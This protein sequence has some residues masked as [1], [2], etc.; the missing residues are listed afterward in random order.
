MNM[1]REV[2][3][4]LAD[5]QGSSGVTLPVV[6][7]GHFLAG[8]NSE[9]A[10]I[11]ARFDAGLR[12][13]GFAVVE[14]H[15]IPQSLFDRMIET[16]GEFFDLAVEDKAKVA[17][18]PS[19]GRFCGWVSLAADAAA[20]IYS[21]NNDTPPDLRERYR[22]VISDAAAVRE[23]AGHNQWPEEVTAFEHVWREYHRMFERFGMQM[24]SLCAVALGLP[25]D[26]FGPYF[27]DH[28]SV[29]MATFSPPL[30]TPAQPGQARCSAHTDMGTLTFVYQPDQYGGI[31]IRL[32]NGRWGIPGLRKGDLIVNGADLLAIWTNDRWR[33]T[34]HRV[35][36]PGT[37]LD[38]RR[39]SIVFFHQPSLDVEIE[40]LPPCKLE[41]EKVRYA[42]ITLRRHFDHNQRKLGTREIEVSVGGPG[43]RQGGGE[44]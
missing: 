8:S 43:A 36:G 23:R 32:P 26:F 37:P 14:N 21:G 18:R 12:V 13:I 22:A 20:N 7:L 39:Q 2:E 15:G 28:F 33:S 24:M 10:D 41:G 40:C 27:E 31:Q 35:G 4:E 42:P 19:E 11:A 9:R 30:T 6:N 38:R 29:L 25:D 44:L 5:G 1:Y 17:S 3:I 34:V 16:T